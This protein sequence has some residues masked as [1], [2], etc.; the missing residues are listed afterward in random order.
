MTRK[1]LIMFKVERTLK[2]QK[3]MPLLVNFAY[4]YFVYYFVQK[5][6]I[7]LNL[8]ITKMNTTK[9]YQIKINQMIGQPKWKLES[10]LNLFNGMMH[11]NQF[12]N[13]FVYQ[14]Q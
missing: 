2:S 10:P 3:K 6:K 8:M 13:L 5:A 7:Y 12:K 9:M 14:I 1:M 11:H 4:I